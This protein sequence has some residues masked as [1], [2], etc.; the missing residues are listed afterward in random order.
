[1]DNLRK[2]HFEKAYYLLGY[3]PMG[4]ADYL[5]ALNEDQRLAVLHGQGPAMV[6]AG[7]GSG[8]TRVL[9]T[10]VAHLLAQQQA[11]PQ[12][13]LLLTFTNKAAG[14]MQT[15]VARLTGHELPFAGTFHRLCAKILRYHAQKIGLPSNFSIYDSDDQLSL[16]KLLLQD[17]GV[18]PKQ[19]HPRAVA[20]AIGEAKQQLIGPD[21]Y[22]QFARGH[23][24]ET[25][26]RIYRLYEKRLTQAGAVDF[27]NLLVKT[28]NLV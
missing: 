23:F 2:L 1:M 26:G 11:Q 13:I 17:L 25:V 5:A 20:A 9:V 8:K 4:S 3:G 12:N 7:A 28:E 27:D 21:E 15:R 10:R 24:Q 22:Q 14:E 19:M 6:L 16:I 18:D